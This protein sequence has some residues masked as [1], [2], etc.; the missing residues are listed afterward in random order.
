ML[1]HWH[2]TGLPIADKVAAK[3]AATAVAPIKE[4]KAGF[5]KVGR[6]DKRLGPVLKGCQTSGL[7]FHT[8]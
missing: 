7:V 1:V 5:G 4:E 3:S 2:I 6:P 8:I